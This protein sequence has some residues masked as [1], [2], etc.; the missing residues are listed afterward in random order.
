MGDVADGPVF[1]VVVNEDLT[2]SQEGK[3]QLPEAFTAD[4][5]MV[6]DLDALDVVPITDEKEFDVG[7]LDPGDGLLAWMDK[8]V[9]LVR[10]GRV[11]PMTVAVMWQPLRH[12]DVVQA[13]YV[14]A[15]TK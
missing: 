15:P 3:V 2:T 4:S 6:Y 14:V 7:M 12:D 13:V 10:V 1:L 11:H 8:E 5:R 9:T